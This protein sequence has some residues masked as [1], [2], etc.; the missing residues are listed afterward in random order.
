MDNKQTKII[1]LF[2]ID[3]P[4][5]LQKDGAMSGRYLASRIGGEQV[6]VDPVDQ[7]QYG[8]TVAMIYDLDGINL[9]RELVMYGLAWV[10]RNY[11]NNADWIQLEQ[12]ARQK[13]I[14]IW[15]R[16]TVQAPWD[17]RRQR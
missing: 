16:K 6:I 10:Y 8:R 14:G 9:N 13:K 15:R 4:E 3:A 17:Y 12:D 5:M 7:D 1:R 11:Y 2:G